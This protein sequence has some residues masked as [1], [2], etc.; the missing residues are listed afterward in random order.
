MFFYTILKLPLK[1]V[2]RN[3][4][5]DNLRF[6]NSTQ[7]LEDLANF[8]RQQ[9]AADPALAD[10]PWIVFGGS[11]AGSLSAWARIR[12]PDL[13]DGAI[14]SSNSALSTIIYPGKNKTISIS[15]FV[16]PR[17]CFPRCNSLYFTIF[18]I[19]YKSERNS[20]SVWYDY[21]VQLY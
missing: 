20:N 2:F 8:I 4:S 17:S 14:S 10:V 13:I 6:L 1:L 19:Q 16:H 3:A 9:K 12:Y 11:Y 18:L 21:K 7:A 5:A 15:S